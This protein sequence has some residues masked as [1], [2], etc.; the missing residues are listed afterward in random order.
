VPQNNDLKSLRAAAQVFYN[1]PRE[2]SK[3]AR[4]VQR[5]ARDIDV[6]QIQLG[7][8]KIYQQARVER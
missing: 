2:G 6:F 7:E 4:L 3:C 8:Y 5:V 1:S